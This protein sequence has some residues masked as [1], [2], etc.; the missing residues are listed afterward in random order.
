MRPAPGSCPRSRSLHDC[1]G[2]AVAAAYRAKWIPGTCRGRNRRRAASPAT[3]QGRHG[4]WTPTGPASSVSAPLWTR[5]R[6]RASPPRPGRRPRPAARPA[7]P[8]PS[9]ATAPPCGVP[10]IQSVRPPASRGHSRH[11]NHRGVQRP[12]PLVTATTRPWPDLWNAINGS[13]RSVCTATDARGL[14]PG[15]GVGRDRRP[16]LQRSGRERQRLTLRHGD[17]AALDARPAALERR[18]A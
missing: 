16:V 5:R 9:S 15:D 10:L 7:D 12:S 11:G 13:P 18:S 1:A 6:D 3:G 17:R 14:R 2:G 4:P 8:T